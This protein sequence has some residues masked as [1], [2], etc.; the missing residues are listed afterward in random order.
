MQHLALAVRIFLFVDVFYNLENDCK[1]SFFEKFDSWQM[2]VDSWSVEGE[3]RRQLD[4]LPND[5]QIRFDK[6]LINDFCCTKNPP[7]TF[8]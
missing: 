8:V 4:E 7:T 3:E 1:I 2:H 6:Y 5:E